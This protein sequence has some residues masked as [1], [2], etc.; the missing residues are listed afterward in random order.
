MATT[1]TNEEYDE[2][3]HFLENLKLLSKTEHA[4]IFE[5][6]HK[7]K[8]EFSENSNGIFFDISKISPDLFSELKAYMNYC[9]QVRTDQAERDA[10][11]R[12]AQDN[13][14]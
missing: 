7:N 13:L 10:E 12:K 3:K 4:K 14:R 5:L 11:E 1:L 8:A 9:T 2:R 6:I